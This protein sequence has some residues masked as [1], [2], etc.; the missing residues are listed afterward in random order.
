[1]KKILAVLML[2]VFSS[3]NMGWAYSFSQFG[4]DLMTDTKEVWSEQVV[5]A[6]GGYD[7]LENDGNLRSKFGID[8]PIIAW[9]F[10]AIAP[11]WVYVPNESNKIGE[12][13]IN[14]SIR[15]GRIP[16]TDGRNLQDLLPQIDKE[17]WTNKFFIGI[18]PT[19]NLST[20]K[21]GFLVNGGYKF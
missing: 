7:L 3:V 9:K 5:R 20:G 21:F 4:D 12:G 19:Q 14:F 8:K 1:M 16:L 10:L 17:T 11:A 13:G 18:A 15:L 2:T 6:F